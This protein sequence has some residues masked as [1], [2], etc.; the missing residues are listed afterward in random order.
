LVHSGG[1]AREEGGFFARPAAGLAEE[2]VASLRFDLRGHGDSEG[3]QEDLTLAAILNDI[4][5]A[6]A[7]L[8]IAGSQQQI[9]STSR[10]LTRRRAPMP[11]RISIAVSGK[12]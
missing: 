1:V 6:A 12:P 4:R 11:R 2:R 3:C 10:E 5:V 7:W 8:R 9:A